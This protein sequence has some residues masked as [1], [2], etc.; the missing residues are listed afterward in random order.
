LVHTPSRHLWLRLASVETPA[1]V[2][3]LATA[4]QAGARL[5]ARCYLCAD[6]AVDR[7]VAAGALAQVPVLE[8]DPPEALASEVARLGTA[9]R[10]LESPDGEIDVLLFT[11][12]Q[13]PVLLRALGRA[14]ELTFRAAG[15]GSGLACDVAP[16]DDDYRHLVLWHRPTRTLMGAYR[17]GVAKDVLAA[18]GQGGLYLDRCFAFD[19]RFQARLGPAIELSRSFVLP[20]HQRDN[21]A[22]ALLWR[23]LGAT[24]RLHGC[25]TLYGCVSVSNRHHPATRALLVEYL[26]RNHADT[27]ALT[28]LVRA[29]RPFVPE[30]TFHSLVGESYAG[31]SLEALAPTVAWLEDGERG[32]PP[33]LRYYVSLGAR[34]LAFHVEPTF[35]DA[36]YCLLRVDLKTIPEGYRRR[37][38]GEQLLGPS[39]KGTDGS[40]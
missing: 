28:R 31:A 14:R 27:P 7:P 5:R 25:T 18:R 34:F 10:V 19:P 30:T 33:L 11:G 3:R 21:R 2:R 23:G 24:A 22:L 35:Q 8:T 32:I 13:S 17:I 20:A 15:Q 1:E 37:F 4:P 40:G 26:Q 36:L 16:E 12:R 29:R 39:D 9:H 38:L 6:R